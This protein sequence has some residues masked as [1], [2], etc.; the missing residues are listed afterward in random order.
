MNLES[1]RGGIQLFNET[2]FFEAH[3]VLEDVWR[4]AP[5]PEKQFLQGLIQIAVAFHH[6][7]TGNLAGARSLLGRG[8]RNLQECPAE[9]GGADLSGLRRALESWH[10]A[11]ADGSSPPPFPKIELKVESDQST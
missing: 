4:A 1:Y 8:R 9:L 5:Q 7:S 10:R 6:Y 11:L 3:E 2:E